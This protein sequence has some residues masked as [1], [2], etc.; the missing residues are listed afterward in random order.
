MSSYAPRPSFEL[1]PLIAEAKRRARYRRLAVIAAV[2]VGA[3]AVG[4]FARWELAGS[5]ATAATASSGEQCAKS[6]TYG[7]QCIEVLGSGRR[8]TEIRTSFDN[9]TMFWPKK[10]WRVDL[11]RYVCDPIGNT[12]ATCWAATTWH[13]RILTGARLVG[14]SAQPAHLVESRSNGYWPTFAVP[15]AFRSNAWLC[16]EVAVYNST[17]RRWVYNA[18]GLAHGLRACVQVHR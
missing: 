5:P 14:R 7:S 11:E 6:D 2:L 1:D 10:R 18:A 9:T 13:G 12:K 4:S 3:L 16:T 17:S 15:H 8:V